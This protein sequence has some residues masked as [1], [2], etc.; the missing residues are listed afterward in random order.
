MIGSLLLTSDAFF[1]VPIFETENRE[2]N[3]DK[4]RQGSRRRIASMGEIPR[5]PEPE[6]A[7]FL[8]E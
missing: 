2:G 6:T 4:T 1:R 8:S 3:E 7:R 5:E